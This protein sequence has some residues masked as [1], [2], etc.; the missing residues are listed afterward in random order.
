MYYAYVLQSDTYKRRYK[1]SYEDLQVRL[2]EHN[3][4][5]TRSTKGFRPWNLVYFEEFKTLAEAIARERYF[6]TAAGRPAQLFG[7]ARPPE[8]FGQALYYQESWPCSSRDTRPTDGHLG[9]G[10]GVS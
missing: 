8:S 4:G 7:Q 5:K 2:K 9:E 6:K 3:A 1:G 10:I